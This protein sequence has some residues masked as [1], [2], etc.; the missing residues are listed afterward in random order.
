[1]QSNP[2]RQIFQ[3]HSTDYKKVETMCIF[4]IY[5]HIFL[6]ISQKFD[7]YKNIGDSDE[8]VKIVFDKKVTITQRRT[9]RHFGDVGFHFSPT[10]VVV[11]NVWKRNHQ[12]QISRGSWNLWQQIFPEHCTA[13]IVKNIETMCIFVIYCHIFESVFMEIE[14]YKEYWRLWRM[15]KESFGK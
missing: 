4:V 8:R 9:R 14:W 10:C 1:M 12:F 3:E 15:N 6:N 5:C 7:W 2:L 11:A 13:L